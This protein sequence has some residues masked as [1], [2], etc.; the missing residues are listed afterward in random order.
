[1]NQTQLEA[2]F[3]QDRLTAILRLVT[4]LKDRVD[5]GELCRS[6][7]EHISH[8]CACREMSDR[9]ERILETEL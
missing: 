2:E 1:M 7:E 4:H 6:H 8:R 5:S 3:L 9:L